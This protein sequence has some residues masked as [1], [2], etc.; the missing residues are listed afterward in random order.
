MIDVKMPVRKAFFQAL[1]NNIT[2]NAT[3]I[4]VAD[5]MRTNIT[6]LGL[7]VILA[8]QTGTPRNTFS[9]WASDETIDIDILYK[10]ADNN[11]KSVLDGVADQMLRLL[12]P[13]VTTNG[14]PTQAGCQ[15]LNL[16]LQSDR[17]LTLSLNP[18]NTL[19][20]RLLT[21]KLYVAQT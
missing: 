18:S 19:G 16:V 1:N 20:R 2:Y 11:A 21:F 15:F 17:D 7:Y 13:S 14:L 4:Q 12:L 9:G 6:P 5:G 8:G 3:P 10:T